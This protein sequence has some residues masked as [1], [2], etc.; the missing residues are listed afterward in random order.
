MVLFPLQ[1]LVGHVALV[2]VVGLVRRAA[3]AGTTLLVFVLLV[4]PAVV[5]RLALLLLPLA[6]LPPFLPVLLPLL[7]V[8]GVQAPKSG[9]D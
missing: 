4:A 1:L 6:L 5:L 3:T 9:S 8:V 2:G 7:R